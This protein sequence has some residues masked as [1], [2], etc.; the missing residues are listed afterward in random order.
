MESMVGDFD[1]L[2]EYDEEEKTELLDK[3][4][5]VDVED[6]PPPITVIPIPVLSVNSCSPSTLNNTIKS[7]DALLSFFVNGCHVHP[8]GGT[9]KLKLHFHPGGT[10]SGFVT[11]HVMPSAAIAPPASDPTLII[12]GV[13]S[14]E[15]AQKVLNEHKLNSITQKPQLDSS[16]ANITSRPAAS[17]NFI[18]RGTDRPLKCPVCSSHYKLSVELRGFI[19]LCSPIITESLQKLKKQQQQQRRKKHRRHKEKANKVSRTHKVASSVDVTS[20]LHQTP[21][22][23][24]DVLP[25]QLSSPSAPSTP[26][27]IQ[28][29]PEAHPCKLFIMVDDFYYGCDVGRRHLAEHLHGARHVGPY[30][31]I[32]CHETLPNNIKLMSH[33]KLHATKMD[34]VS[35]CPHCFRHFSSLLMLQCHMDAVHTQYESTAKCKICELD[36]VSEP[37]LLMH[38]KTTHKVG[39]MPYICQVCDFRSSFYSDVWN[40]FEEVHADTKNLMCPYCL[41]VLKSSSCYQQHFAKHQEKNVLGCDKCRLHFLYVKERLQ[42]KREHHCTHITPTQLKGLKPG[43]KVTVRMYSALAGVVGEDV[44]SKT[45]VPCKV[46]E[47]GEALPS[48]ESLKKKPRESL[49]HLLCNLSSDEDDDSCP[50]RRCVECLKSIEKFTAHFPSM[51][52]CSLCT[53]TTCCS[54]AYANHMI[55]EHTI[56]KKM[57]HYDSIFQ[58]HT[59]LQEKLK[60]LSC[61]YVTHIGDKMA[62]HLIEQPEHLCV[63]STHSK[64][65]LNADDNP[66]MQ[67]SDSVALSRDVGKA[68][69]P[70]HLLSSHQPNPQLSIKAL[71]APYA[72]S[73]PAAMTIKFMGPCPPPEELTEKKQKAKLSSVTPPLLQEQLLSY[74]EWEWRVAMWVLTRR[75][76]QLQVSKEVLLHTGQIAARGNARAAESYRRVVDFLLHDPQPTN[77]HGHLPRKLLLEVMEKS[78]TFILSLCSQ[79]QSAALLPHCVGFMDELTI[80]VNVDK[81]SKQNPAAFS[82]LGLPGEMP[83]FDVV[84]SAMSDGTSLTPMLFY[85]G[86]PMDIPAEFPDNVLLEARPGGFTDTLRLHTWIQKVWHHRPP[87]KK[88]K[89]LLMLD[90]YRGHMT[91]EFKSDLSAAS[92]DPVFIPAGCCS[93]LQPLDVCVKP[94]LHNFLQSRWNSLVFQGGLEGLSLNQLALTLTCW[95]SEM[96]STLSSDANILRRSFASV[97]HLQKEQKDADVMIQILTSKLVQPIL[98]SPPRSV[99]LVLVLQDNN[100][101][102]HQNHKS[103][104]DHGDANSNQQM[105]T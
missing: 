84:L 81:F 6:A 100:Q 44:H 10:C 45:L 103:Q 65:I 41:R 83:L 71:T 37:S 88:S 52:C 87:S 35:S 60:C 42:H 67:N 95:L 73:S 7:S 4:E 96:S 94:V 34:A 25:D 28:E 23:S 68:F 24:D 9:T 97:C 46:V 59:R 2:M 53:F 33:M 55:R 51:V 91:D 13:V 31:C 75:E 69:V 72:L 3:E 105:K 18:P 70:V 66:P 1:S 5:S 8:A 80:Y 98:P 40:H 15:A 43:T 32:H 93:R 86:E 49:R 92:T 89:S 74:D 58:I 50:F 30:R 101:S 54:N 77:K 36:F 102:L 57:P 48:Q 99:Q 76:Q 56:S 85:R 39:E 38:L 47:V 63:M 104:L 26:R 78:R 17:K 79:I 14:G 29:E 21:C 27:L 82:L 90:V 64:T 19:C 22:L 62:A 16:T 12:T 11:V 61:S 20:P